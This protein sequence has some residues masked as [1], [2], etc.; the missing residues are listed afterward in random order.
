MAGKAKTLLLAA[1]VVGSFFCYAA[2][3]IKEVLNYVNITTFNT[4]LEINPDILSSIL[5]VPAIGA[6]LYVAKDYASKGKDESKE[7]STLSLEEIARQ[8]EELQ[9]K[10][11]E[12]EE[13]QELKSKEEIIHDL[14]DTEFYLEHRDDKIKSLLYKKKVVK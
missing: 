14:F 4:L 3:T 9:Q 1:T 11:K 6:S 10:K 5:A 2:P 8:R 13:A 12:I 7:E